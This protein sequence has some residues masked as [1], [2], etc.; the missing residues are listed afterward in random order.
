MSG[1]MQFLVEDLRDRTHSAP[2][3]SVS[4]A[5]ALLHC[6]ALH[7]LQM[8]AEK[9]HRRRASE[10]VLGVERVWLQ[11]NMLEKFPSERT[12]LHILTESSFNS[13]LAVG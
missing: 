11:V 8:F 10:G 13:F 1:F 2:G 9:F 7:C 4:K 3:Q 5:C 12:V 6:R